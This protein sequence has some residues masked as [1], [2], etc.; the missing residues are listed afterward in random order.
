MALL[1]TARQR[2]GAPEVGKKARSKEAS[3]VP[4][5]YEP[6]RYLED[7]FVPRKYPGRIT[8]FWPKD[9]EE[10]PEDAASRWSKVARDVELHV[11]P[12]NH[13][14]CIT[15]YAPLLARELQTCL[16]KAR[17]GLHGAK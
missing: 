16:T 9:D 11:L 4:S 14:T 3:A 17:H 7:T 5:P 12:G 13:L 8:L 15:K 6:Y 2:E 10:S 1:A